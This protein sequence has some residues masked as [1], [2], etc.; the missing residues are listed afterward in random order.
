MRVEVL[1]GGAAQGLVAALEAQFKA[2]TGCDIAGTFGAVGAMRE[3][4]LAGARAD[5][6]ILTS[7]LIAEL[8]RSGHVVAGSVVDVGVVETGVATRAGD[9]APA[10]GNADELRAALLAADAIYFPDPK[11][12]TAGIHFAKALERLGIGGDVA[13]RLQPHPNGAAAMR[14]LSQSGAA[15]PIG[16]TQVTEI[17]ATPGVTLA[18]PLP[19]GYE[20]ATVYTAGICTKAALPAEAARLAALLSSE[21]TGEARAKAGFRPLGSLSPLRSGER[22]INAPP[23]SAP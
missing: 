19:E 11:Q 22:E 7:A 9:P 8:A 10:V 23:D 4:L 1:S 17:L 21:T 18:G 15:R 13:A 12:A 14:A 20:L 5:L 2:E 16:C 6:L 3:K